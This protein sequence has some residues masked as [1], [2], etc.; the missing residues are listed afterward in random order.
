MKLEATI[1]GTEGHYL[2]LNEFKFN[3]DYLSAFISIRSNWYNAKVKFESSRERMEEFIVSLEVLVSY[4]TDN[5]C[6]INDDGNVDINFSLN[7]SGK[8]TLKGCLINDMMEESSL[9]YEIESD[10]QSINDFYFTL[11]KILSSFNDMK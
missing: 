10:L 2:T 3:G 5:I 4:K 9:T 7:T 6:F 1:F 8:V 11:K